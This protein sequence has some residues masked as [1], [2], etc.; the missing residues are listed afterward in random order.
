[1]YITDVKNS[2]EKAYNVHKLFI[3]LVSI[4]VLQHRNVEEVTSTLSKGKE[5]DVVRAELTDELSKKFK[6]VMEKLG[7]PTKTSTV[8]H[9]INVAY[10][11][12]HNSE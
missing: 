1:V 6:Y 12:E 11:R 2:T 4:T 3:E 10:D 5:K 9:L 8:I 7:F